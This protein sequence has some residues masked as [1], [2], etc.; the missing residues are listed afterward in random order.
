MRPDIAPGSVFPDFEL[1][2]ETGERRRLSEIQG[3]DPLCLV[4]SRGSY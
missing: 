4:L 1:P 2:D 3:R